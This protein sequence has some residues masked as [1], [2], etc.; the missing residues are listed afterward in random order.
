MKWS[1]RL[2]VLV[3]SIPPSGCGGREESSALNLPEREERAELP[4]EAST[5]N[6]PA[7]RSNESP[8]PGDQPPGFAP[9][10]RFGWPDDF[11]LPLVVEIEVPEVPEAIR[12]P[13]SIEKPPQ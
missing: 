10:G 13:Q 1:L 4:E 5:P 2:L 6:D 7:A 3:L 9:G 12:G 11:L 8:V